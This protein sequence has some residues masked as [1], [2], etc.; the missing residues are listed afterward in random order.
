MKYIIR[1]LEHLTKGKA[2]IIVPHTWK[3]IEGGQACDKCGIISPITLSCPES[4]D[5]KLKE[6]FWAEKSNGKA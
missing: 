3:I 2:L 5:W 1:L 6:V 4:R